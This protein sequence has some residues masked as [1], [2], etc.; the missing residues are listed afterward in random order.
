MEL[1][2]YN[3]YNEIHNQENNNN[4]QN[5]DME[6][7]NSMMK[8]MNLGEYPNMFFQ[9]NSN[10][11][12]NINSNQNQNEFNNFGLGGPLGRNLNM[13]QINN[14]NINIK[15]EK[16]DNNK[17]F[18]DK[19][20]NISIPL[21]RTKTSEN[22]THNVIIKNINKENNEKNIEKEKNKDQV[23]LKEKQN[24]ENIE[25]NEENESYFNKEKNKKTK[26]ILSKGR[27]DLKRGYKK[28]TIYNSKDNQKKDFQNSNTFS[29]IE[30]NI[31]LSKTQKE[32]ISNIE[33]KKFSIRNKYKMRKMNEMV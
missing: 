17:L 32:S 12:N 14:Q 25:S 6:N 3:Y 2:D 19:R 29:V 18:I 21:Y 8:N 13:N 20:K 11:I 30:N 7:L 9:N 27:Y 10:N 4:E 22:E 16:N 24:K 1:N 15:E 26:E 33:P 23:I 28:M 31:D 5:I